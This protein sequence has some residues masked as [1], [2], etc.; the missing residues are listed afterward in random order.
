MGNYF[1]KCNFC[2]QLNENPSLTQLDEGAFDEIEKLE[3][4]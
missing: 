1:F 3:K 2:R 4:L